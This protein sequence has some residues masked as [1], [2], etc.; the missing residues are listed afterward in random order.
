[1]RECAEL[2][3][4]SRR[5]AY[6]RLHSLGEAAGRPVFVSRV[7]QGKRKLVVS[8]SDAIR[9]ARDC[10]LDVENSDIQAMR[11]TLEANTSALVDVAATVRAIAKKMGVA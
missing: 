4:C 11:E 2:A 8:K 9:A 3:G 7:T 10:G 5:T 1:V 6:R